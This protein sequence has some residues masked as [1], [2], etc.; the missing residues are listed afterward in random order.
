MIDKE[1]RII[2][3]AWIPVMVILLLLVL[4]YIVN[5]ATS[6]YM[7]K[8]I[9]HSL[10]GLNCPGCGSQRFLHFILHGDLS[11]AIRS[12]LLL[13][14]TLPYLIFWAAIEIW[15]GSPLNDTGKLTKVA[16]IR[17]RL[18]S[19]CAI[20]IICVVIAAWTILR[21]LPWYPYK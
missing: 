15:P 1:R 8:C 7:P 11:G 5:P 6:D 3:G 13:V 21:N 19:P 20:I 12:N 18:N 17:N 4:Y 10:T 2:R 9:V 14:V 16:K